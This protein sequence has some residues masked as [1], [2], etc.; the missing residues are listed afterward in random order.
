MTN[1]KLLAVLLAAA[2]VLGLAGCEETTTTVV[3]P[4]PYEVGDVLPGSWTV[5]VADALGGYMAERLVDADS[6][7]DLDF[8]DDSSDYVEILVTGRFGSDISFTKHHAAYPT[9][10]QT[11]YLS[12]QVIIG[13]DNS[14]NAELTIEAG[15]LIKGEVS[16][17]D[18]GVL[19]VSR[20]STINAAGTST[21]PIVF[22]SANDEGDRAQGDWGGIVLLGNGISNEGPGAVAEAIYQPWG[23]TNNADSSGTL[24]YVRVEFAGTFFDPENELNGIAF[25]GVG[26]G[27]TVDHVQIHCNKDDGLE[28]FG[29]AVEASYVVITG[30]GDDSLDWDNG[31]VGG[32]QHLIIQQYGSPYAADKLIEADGEADP[33]SDPYVANVTIMSPVNEYLNMK[34]G[35]LGKL[36]N[37]VIVS[38]VASP[39]QVNDTAASTDF[40]YDGVIIE[41]YEADDAP[42][43]DAA[44]TATTPNVAVIEQT[45]Y[46]GSNQFDIDNA[47]FTVLQGSVTAVDATTHGAPAAAQYIGAYNGSTN[48]WSSWTTEAEN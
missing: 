11:Y 41:G 3:D 21:D 39:A 29:G 27:T 25:Y 40:I 8:G 44:A 38:S 31:W 45:N 28:F 23:G 10:D 13:N 6:E 12:S 4:Q 7:D 35:T 42:V 36:V 14:S 34:V 22:T 43:F 19:I 9:L 16:S 33:T 17:V 46:D 47:I 20:G 15:T 30:A 1:S 37:T 18:P 5:T 2:L 26:S 24:Q 48:W 32:I